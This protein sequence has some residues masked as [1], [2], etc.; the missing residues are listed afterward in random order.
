MAKCLR[1]GNSSNFNVWCSIQKVLEVEL[2]GNEE[3]VEIIGEPE[4]ESLHGLEEIELMED[5]LAF[6]MVSFLIQC[7]FDFFLNI[8]CDCFYLNARVTM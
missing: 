2:S 1:C 3:L 8:L 4:D 7:L 5:D 6:A